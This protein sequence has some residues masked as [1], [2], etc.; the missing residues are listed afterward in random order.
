MS[1]TVYKVY[2]N[3]FIF[4]IEIFFSSVAMAG[5]RK[6]VKKWDAYTSIS[7]LSNIT[8]FVIM[9][10]LYYHHT[11]WLL[12]LIVKPEDEY[13]S[14]KI[15]VEYI[16]IWI[17]LSIL[18]GSYVIW[19]WMDPGFSHRDKEKKLTHESF[20]KLIERSRSANDDKRLF[21]LSKYNE[22]IEER[23]ALPI[24]K[25]KDNFDFSLY[26]E[27]CE[28]FRL[29]RTHHCSVC[30]DWVYNMD[31]HWTWLNNCVGYRNHRYFVTLLFACAISWFYYNYYGFPYYKEITIKNMVFLS[32]INILSLSWE[33]FGYFSCYNA[34]MGVIVVWGL[35][36]VKI[37]SGISRGV[38][39]L[40][41]KKDR[42][43]STY[44]AG[45][46][47]NWYLSYGNWLFPFSWVFCAWLG[48]R[49]SIDEYMSS[50]YEF[51][52]E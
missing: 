10:W 15:A 22:N 30:N 25:F 28:R 49:K 21:G 4:E 7:I 47:E 12:P 32:P 1:F 34:G 13:Y 46:E 37:C 20:R 39:T 24:E 40:E 5:E 48:S 38:S 45:F 3:K 8:G 42:S 9:G 6:G 43:D 29:P 16:L 19:M 50:M 52:T 41:F 26:C 44:D 2:A 18:V 27:K 17:S 51:E 31:H 14:F 36:F 23:L 33:Q 11:F 35:H